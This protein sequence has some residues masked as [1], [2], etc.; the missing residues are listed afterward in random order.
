MAE[1]NGLVGP[2]LR[3]NGSLSSEKV[4]Q[5]TTPMTYTRAKRKS[6][7]KITPLTA[8]SQWPE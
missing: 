6:T 5:T 3:S 7:A 8:S 4:I 2:L 1:L